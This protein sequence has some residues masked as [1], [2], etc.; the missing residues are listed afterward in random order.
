ML[1]GIH[2]QQEDIVSLICSVDF[3]AKLLISN[4]LVVLDHAFR[5]LVVVALLDDHLL[6]Q[7]DGL[8]EDS[9]VTLS[10]KVVGSVRVH[11]PLLI[12]GFHI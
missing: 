6:V 8:V 11:A 5:R 1:I 3:G 7:V 4:Q 12:Q 2:P 9:C 10:H